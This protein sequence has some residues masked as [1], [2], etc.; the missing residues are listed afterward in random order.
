VRAAKE[1]WDDDGPEHEW[2]LLSDREDEAAQIL[3][4]TPAP[5][6]CHL[7]SKFEVFEHYLMKE[8]RDGA[9]VEKPCVAY[10]GSIKA[11]LLAHGIG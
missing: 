10:L 2:S 5:N 11:D 1:S 8:L 9:Y 6:A 3:M 7:C 4:S